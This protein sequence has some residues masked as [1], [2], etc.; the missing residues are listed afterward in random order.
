MPEN[1]G[2]LRRSLHLVAPDLRPQWGM[3]LAGVLALMLE[4][5]FRSW[6]PGP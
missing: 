6:S 3:V 1:R 5:G 4:V 2:A